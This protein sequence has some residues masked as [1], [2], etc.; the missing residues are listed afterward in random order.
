MVRR[1]IRVFG[2][3]GVSAVVT[4]GCGGSSVTKHDE[5]ATAGTSRG[6]SGAAGGIGGTTGGST[7]GGPRGGTGGAGGA[8]GSFGVS[9]TG[10]FGGVGVSGGGFGGIGVS[11]G[12][13]G[14]IGVSGG[15][16]GGIAGR[17][18]FGSSGC[19]GLTCLQGHVMLSCP[20]SPF[21]QCNVDVSGVECVPDGSSC[22]F[23]E[24]GM[25]GANEAGANGQ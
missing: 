13:F 11:G 25:G 1:A 14:G 16:F 17:G 3:L 21:V 8:S 22:P 12:G 15:G 9:G 7:G 18:G 6:G 5:P 2:V 4:Q 19:D 24:G 10:A 20:G 23:G